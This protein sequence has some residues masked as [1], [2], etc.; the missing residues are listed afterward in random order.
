MGLDESG[1]NE[2]RDMPQELK[3]AL[4]VHRAPGHGRGRRANRAQ[5]IRMVTEGGAITTSSRPKSG[6]R[7]KPTSPYQETDIPML[8]A[9]VHRARAS[10]SMPSEWTAN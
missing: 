9:L 4:R 5:I 1:I 6:G 7:K 3:L 8:D 2:D 10:M